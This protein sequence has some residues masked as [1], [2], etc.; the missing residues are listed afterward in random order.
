MVLW[1]HLTSQDNDLNKHDVEIGPVVLEKKMKMQKITTTM[2]TDNGQILIG[3]APLRAFSSGDVKMTPILRYFEMKL[4]R[5]N[6]SCI[7]F[8]VRGLHV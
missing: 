6:E 4:S 2:T 8:L 7:E 1:P 3:K 5:V